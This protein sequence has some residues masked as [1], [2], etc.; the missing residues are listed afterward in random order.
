MGAGDGGQGGEGVNALEV[1]KRARQNW[2]EGLGPR[3]PWS[4]HYGCIYAVLEQLAEDVQR[5][6]EQVRSL[7]DAQWPMA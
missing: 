2:R 5:L 7:G 3:E 4:E 6:K 1:I